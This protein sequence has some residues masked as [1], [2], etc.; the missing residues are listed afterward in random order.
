MSNVKLDSFQVVGIAVRTSNHKGAA[1]V[2]IPAH[3]Q[4]F[5]ADQIMQQIPNKSSNEIYA[6]YTNYEGD[7]T[8]PY[9]FVLGCKVESTDHIPEDMVSITIASS[10]YEQFTVKGDLEKGRIVFDAWQNIW[11]SEMNRAYEV[12]FEVYGEKSQDMSN[13]EVDIFVSI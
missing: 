6:I 4:K 7:Y 10:P 2:D 12:D 3:W 9:D 5:M 8:S 13:A 1:A 11:K